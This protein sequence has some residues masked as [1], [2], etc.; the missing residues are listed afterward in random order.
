MGVMSDIHSGD[1]P[2][3]ILFSFACMYMLYFLVYYGRYSALNQKL[4]KVARMEKAGVVAQ[5]TIDLTRK[6]TLYRIRRIKRICYV[7]NGIVLLIH[8]AFNGYYFGKSFELAN[9]LEPVYLALAG[10]GLILLGNITKGAQIF[11]PNRRFFN[12]GRF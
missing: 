6:N 3:F 4:V 8:W 9:F 10:A 1:I 7:P 11:D 12:R 2:F 5:S